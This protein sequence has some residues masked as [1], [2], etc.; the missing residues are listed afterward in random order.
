[1]DVACVS[2][3]LAYRPSAVRSACPRGPIVFTGGGNLGDIWP[4][5]QALRERVIRDFPDRPIVQ[6]PQSVSFRDAHAAR[7]FSQ[8]C[9]SHGGVR[10]MTRDRPSQQRLLEQCGL[11][12]VLCPDVAYMLRPERRAAPSVPVRWLL[13]QDREKARGSDVPG[14]RD[15]VD[16]WSWNALSAITGQF[17]M[18][19]LGPRAVTMGKAISQ[20]FVR[21]G[22]SLLSSARVVVTDRLHAA[23]LS[24]LLGIPHVVLDNSYGKL[25]G[26]YQTWFAG[27]RDMLLATSVEEA[28]LMA[29]RLL[30]L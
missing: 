21:N 13:R 1:M 29:D 2:S 30:E 22:I 5:E 15:W 10:M 4:H 18:P 27:R 26:F 16:R 28:R 14:A 17:A 20:R 3:P 9:R 24:S 11:E 25:T 7:R 6:L 8:L 12:S 19:F 23:I